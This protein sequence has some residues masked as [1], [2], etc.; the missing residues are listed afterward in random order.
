MPAQPVTAALIGLAFLITLT[1][2]LQI[3]FW[4]F[5]TDDAYITFRYAARWLS[6]AG[7]TFNPGE[8]VEGFSNPLWL[9]LLAG[10]VK[11][12]GGSLVFWAQ[13]LGAA[14]QLLTF[15][16]LFWLS[17][18]VRVFWLA[19]VL[20]LVT[21]GVQVYATLGLEVP[22][23]MCLLTTGVAATVHATPSRPAWLLVAGV[24]FGLAGITRPEG[25]LYVLLWGVGV[26]AAW[27]REKKFGWIVTAGLIAALPGAAYQVFR[28]LYFGAWVPNTAVAKTAGLFGTHPFL[29]EWTPWLPTV[30]GL[31]A[32]ALLCPPAQ[33][34]PATRRANLLTT[35]P[36]LGGVIFSLYAGADWMLFGRFLLP[37]WPLVL[38]LLCR[39]LEVG[40]V[41]YPPWRAAGVRA[42]VI[43]ASAAG[44]LQVA[45]PFLANQGL[46]AMLMRG[47]D[48]VTVGRWLDSAF[49][50]PRVMATNRIGAVSYYGA[51]HIFRDTL[52]LTD[53]TQAQA[54]RA[55][56][57]RFAD[58]TGLTDRNTTLSPLPDLLLITRP[59]RS[60]LQPPYT[61]AERIFLDPRYTLLRQ[62][63]QGNWGTLD[64]WQRRD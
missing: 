32:V 42:L 47:T 15:V 52:G 45:T 55:N 18:S 37:V 61:E 59:P 21:P 53:R 35:G 8:R 14:F 26:L 13:T 51:H 12:F 63:A 44:W 17:P 64:V 11:L 36:V 20:L 2:A 29:T 56:P 24:C 6:G 23:L 50:E 49:P 41:A 19:L 58:I 4:P 38:V 28:V 7:L 25:P 3:W 43:G 30:F 34:D 33:P 62:F 10:Q 31:L 22:L 46:A 16:A 60:G 48:Q 27:R 1:G 5:V 39:R 40:L 57:D 9:F 54:I